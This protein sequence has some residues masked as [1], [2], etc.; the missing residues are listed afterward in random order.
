MNQTKLFYI[1]GGKKLRESLVDEPLLPL[2]EWI[3]S[4]APSSPLSG[5]EIDTV[6]PIT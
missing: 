5:P 1:D 3:I 6:S 4:Q 2:T